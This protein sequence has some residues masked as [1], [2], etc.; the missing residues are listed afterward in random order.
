MGTPGL[1]TEV[2]EVWHRETQ[3]LLIILTTSRIHQLLP[4]NIFRYFTTSN[5][6]FSLAKDPVNNE[7][8]L[9]LRVAGGDE[10][11]F[12]TLYDMYHQLLATYIFR[13]TKSMTETEEIVHDVFLKIWMARESL[14]EIKNAKAY[15]FVVSRNHALNSINRRVREM[16][17]KNQWIQDSNSIN[18]TNDHEDDSLHTLIDK[19]I[20]QLPP[21]QK[22]VFLLSRHEKLTY[23]EIASN[24]D[25]SRETVKTYLKHATTSI[26][27]YIRENIEISLLIMFFG[28]R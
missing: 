4:Q 6:T 9:L 7:K 22:K 8:E 26:T 3:R 16:L 14:A 17:Q 2:T 23:H 12:R 24:M 15:L 10:I 19:A 20:D 27:K 1:T 18:A 11:A 13:L 25:I 21:Q 5:S 28:G